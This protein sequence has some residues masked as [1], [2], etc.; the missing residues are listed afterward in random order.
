MKDTISQFSYFKEN[1]DRANPVAWKS[2]SSP[3]TSPETGKPV[4]SFT[5][6]CRYPDKT[7]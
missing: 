5:L 1:L 7:R 4:V 2:S 6:E 3:M